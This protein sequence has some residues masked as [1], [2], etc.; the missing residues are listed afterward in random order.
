MPFAHSK[1]RPAPKGAV[2]QNKSGGGA[3][4]PHRLPHAEKDAV[5]LVRG[6]ARLDI[7]IVDGDPGLARLI[8]ATKRSSIS[9]GPGRSAG[10]APRSRSSAGSFARS[11]SM[12]PEIL[13]PDILPASVRT[14]KA[15]QSADVR[16]ECG[17][18]RGR[19]SRA[20]RTPRRA[21]CSSRCSPRSSGSSERPSI[22]WSCGGRPSASRRSARRRPPRR[23]A[24]RPC[25]AWRRPRHR[26]RRR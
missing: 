11:K 6:R 2:S 17:A 8:Q 5:L 7:G 9:R 1:P 26:D 25:R 24:R 13:P 4:A 21:R 23:S 12:R 14:M 20:P 19:N 3:T 16:P 22:R 15:R 10:S 18:P